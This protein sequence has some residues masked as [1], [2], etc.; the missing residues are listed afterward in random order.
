MRDNEERQSIETGGQCTVVGHMQKFSR[1][2][3]MSGVVKL[4]WGSGSWDD[5]RRS[6]HTSSTTPEGVRAIRWGTEVFQ[7]IIKKLLRLISVEVGDTDL[8]ICG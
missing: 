1:S 4:E 2:I 5:L 7:S 8:R 3:R 6:L